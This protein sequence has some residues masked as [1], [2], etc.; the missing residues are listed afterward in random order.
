MI[1]VSGEWMRSKANLAGPS[2]AR[3]A[4][5][6]TEGV[7]SLLADVDRYCP[8]VPGTIFV[9][10]NVKHTNVADIGKE[11]GRPQD[12]E[13]LT[14]QI[15]AVKITGSGREV[16]LDGFLG[17]PLVARDFYFFDHLLPED[18]KGH[19]AQDQTQ[20]NPFHYNSLIPYSPAKIKTASPG[21]LKQPQCNPLITID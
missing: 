8:N 1:V 20:N 16:I 17:Y 12:L 7:Y 21:A 4:A 6:Q 5:R 13:I 2:P 14:K 11:S 19:E 15:L 18:K 10:K 3:F 9:S